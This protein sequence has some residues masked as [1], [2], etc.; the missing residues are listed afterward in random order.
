MALNHSGDNVCVCVC[1]C[2]CVQT[3]HTH[4]NTHFKIHNVDLYNVVRNFHKIKCISIFKYFKI[5][6]FKYFK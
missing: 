5:Y 1:V 3:S 6:L 4:T 2:V